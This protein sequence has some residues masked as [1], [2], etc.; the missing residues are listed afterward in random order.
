[1]AA[2]DTGMH[3]VQLAGAR[4]PLAASRA[5]NE[6]RTSD[7]SANI[8]QDEVSEEEIIQVSD[9]DSDVEL[10]NVC[11]ARAGPFLVQSSSDS[12]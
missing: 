7:A 11:P 6:H 12:D 9:S 10:L 3:G 2:F 5:S 8:E 4:G 1:M